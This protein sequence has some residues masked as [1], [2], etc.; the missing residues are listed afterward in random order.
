MAPLDKIET[1]MANEADISLFMEH[2]VKWVRSQRRTK[3][4]RLLGPSDISPTMRRRLGHFVAI[5][6]QPSGLF[7][8]APED[9]GSKNIGFHG[10]LS[11]DEMS[12]PLIV[13]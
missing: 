8:G 2:A 5:S 12:L 11:P 6:R 10:G 4:L 3:R 13:L 1:S 7:I 9:S